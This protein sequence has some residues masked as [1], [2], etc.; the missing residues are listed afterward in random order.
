MPP[1]LAIAIAIS[2]SVTV[3]IAEDKKGVCNKMFFDRLSEMFVS[4][5]NTFEKQG[6][7]NTSSKVNASFIASI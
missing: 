3:S 5:G 1:D 7:S 6:L 4:E 2:D